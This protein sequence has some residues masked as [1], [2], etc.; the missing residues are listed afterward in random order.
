MSGFFVTP[1]TIARQAPLSVGFS[2]PEKLEWVA[3]SFSRVSSWPRGQMPI[4][5]IGR[6][7]LYH[8]AIWEALVPLVCYRFLFYFPSQH[9]MIELN[10]FLLFTNLEVIHYTSV[11]YWHL[12][13]FSVNSYNNL[14]LISNLTFLL[15]NIGT[16]ELL[17]LPLWL[18][19]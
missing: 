19:W 2:I 9:E 17:G 7:I 18:S 13:N 14:K 15:D 8:W 12:G 4:S 3:I 6:W 5:Y 1:W 16:L 11:F 10:L